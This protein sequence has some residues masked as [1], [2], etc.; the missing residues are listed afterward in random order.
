MTIKQRDVYHTT[1]Y[2][3]GGSFGMTIPPDLRVLMKLQPGDH[4]AMNFSHGILWVIKITPETIIPRAK[5]TAI[6]DEL[7]PD[8]AEGRESNR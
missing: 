5:V 7:F 2:R 6:I 4:L 8:K 3:V 1:Y